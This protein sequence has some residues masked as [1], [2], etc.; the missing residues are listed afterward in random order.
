MF[1][2]YVV[3]Y[4]CINDTFVIVIIIEIIN[5]GDTYT[6]QWEDG[7]FHGQ[8]RFQYHDKGQYIG[9]YS[10]GRRQGQGVFRLRDGHEYEGEWNEDLPAGKGKFTD[11]NGRVSE[12]DF[13]RRYALSQL[14][15]DGLAFS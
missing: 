2:L 7:Q 9:E 14:K 12:G 8:G 4:F 13:Q 15:L 1:L 11:D 3:V 10:R 5:V 6:G